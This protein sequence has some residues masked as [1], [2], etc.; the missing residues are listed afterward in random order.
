MVVGYKG[1]WVVSR[2]E[3]VGGGGERE[4]D[5]KINLSSPSLSS[6][7][8]EKVTQCHQ[9]NIIFSFVFFFINNNE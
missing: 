1:V 2:F 4:R 9:N 3:Q 6:S 8:E 5:C 7:R